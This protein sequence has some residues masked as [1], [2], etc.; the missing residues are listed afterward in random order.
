MTAARALLD[1]EH[2]HPLAKDRH[3]HDSNV[4][5]LGLMQRH[6]VVIACLTEYGTDSAAV[7]TR[8][9][10]HSFGQIRFVLMVGVGGG[11]PSVINDI[12]LGDVVVSTPSDGKGGVVQ[13]DFGKKNKRG[14]V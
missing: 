9:M 8:Q 3:A 4:Y 1:E 5:H 13:Y 6:N 11:M 14:K 2:D 7:V 10:L 12:R